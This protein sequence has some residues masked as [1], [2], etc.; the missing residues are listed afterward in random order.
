M[1]LLIEVAVLL[2]VVVFL[3]RRRT[4]SRSRSDRRLTFTTVLALGVLIAPTPAA[5]G[6]LS[7]LLDLA[8]GVTR[9]RR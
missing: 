4:K 8:V 2:M 1:L 9:A 5:P 3:R 6:I 7:V